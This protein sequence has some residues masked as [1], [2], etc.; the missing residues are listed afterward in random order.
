MPS[1]S[2]PTDPDVCLP[3]PVSS[4]SIA[5]VGV[6]SNLDPEVHVTKALR[7]LSQVVHIVGISEFYRTPAVDRPSQ[8]DYLNG[9]LRIETCTAP[10]A[11]K[12]DVLRRVEAEMG[13]QRQTD[14]LA[15]RCIDLD[16]VL[17]DDL[18][19]QSDLL[20]LPDP[21]IFQRAFVSVPLAEL[22][23]DKLVPG[24]GETAAAIAARA[25]REGMRHEAEFTRDLRKRFLS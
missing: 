24:A 25:G 9:M 8:P 13:R 12:T 4:A 1:E 10:L 15:S 7:I 6:G 22:A 16:L 18:V 3:R 2:T 23:G 20:Q 21:D 14:K 11:L 19:I 17:Y 5:Y